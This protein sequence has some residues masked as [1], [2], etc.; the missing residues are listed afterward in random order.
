MEATAITIGLDV[1]TKEDLRACATREA[2]TALPKTLRP[3]TSEPEPPLRAALA[4]FG[5]FI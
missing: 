5:E 1:S 2:H 4:T 3:E